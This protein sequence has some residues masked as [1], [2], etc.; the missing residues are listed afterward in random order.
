MY[1]RRRDDTSGLIHPDKFEARAHYGA[2]VIDDGTGVVLTTPTSAA[3]I[4]GAP[5]AAG[6]SNGCTL[7]ATDGSITIVRPGRYAVSFAAGEV[8][9]VNNQA[10]TIEV[11][12]GAAVLAKALLA[13]VTQPATALAIVSLAASGI[14]DLEKGDVLTLRATGSTGNVT[15]KRLRFSAVQI[16]DDAVQ[17]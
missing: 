7:S 5:M 2:L 12:K 14:V 10:L 8:V 3:D 15:V 9:G 6:E 1:A 13:K 4:K 11:Y 17:P 16:D